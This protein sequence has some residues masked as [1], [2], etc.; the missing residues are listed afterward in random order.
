MKKTIYLFL[1]S[2]FLFA[3]SSEQNKL[4]QEY[5]NKQNL[6]TSVEKGFLL[7]T[8]CP[9]GFERN[10]NNQCV[11]RSMY[12]M[13]DSPN[14]AGVGGLQTGL[15]EI[16]DG[17][18][19]QQIDLGRY[20]FFDP[21]LSKDGSVSCASCHQPDKGFADGKAFSDGVDGLKTTRS[22]PSLW[23]V[24]F[25]KRLKWDASTASLEEQMKG[26]LYAENEMGNTPENLLKTLNDI[27]L[28]QK[29]FQEAFPKKKE[30]NILE[31]EIYTAIAAFQSSLISLNSKYDQYA[32]GNHDALSEQEIKGMNV[33]R[34]FVARCAECHTPPLFTN[35]QI[36]VIGTPEPA[37]NPFDKG[38]AIPRKDSS[39]N[40]GFK[41]P[42]LRNIAL[43]APYNHSGKFATLEETTRFY[44]QGRA[45]AVPDSINL[46]VHWH[47]W[48]PE[49]P[50][51]EIEQITA[52]LKT[53]TDES[54]KPKV[55]E[56]N[57]SGL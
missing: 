39:L 46:I 56:K 32:H 12:N 43:T 3:C 49:L 17:F 55:P 13:Y 16:R 26:P 34:S 2:V 42:S 6:E 36:A 57:P 45:H 4:K 8:N 28:Y 10:E 37:G 11:H 52:F 1:F 25:L 14:N 19:P 21:I 23:N 30:K 35:Q 41:V 53:L 51:Y 9:P 50:E 5:T 27:D 38:A 18:S 44:T 48:E 24:A 40:G 7:S 22:A 15:P 29:L 47:I 54:F 20:L 31:N 33:F